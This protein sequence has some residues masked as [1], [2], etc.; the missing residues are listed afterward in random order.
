MPVAV[1][2]F[3]ATTNGAAAMLF[4]VGLRD[5]DNIPW[6]AVIILSA[7]GVLGANLRDELANSVEVSFTL[8]VLAAAMALAGPGGAVLVGFFSYLLDFRKSTMVSRL[9]N[10]AMSACVSGVGANVYALAEGLDPYDLGVVSSPANLLAYLALPMFAG[11]L[12]GLLTNVALIGLMAHF[13]AGVNPFTA[14]LQ[15]VHGLGPTYPVHVLLGILLVVLWAPVGIGPFSSVLIVGPLWLTQWALSRDADERRSHTRTV[16]TLMGAL[17]VATPYS[18][19]HSSRVADLTDRMAPRLGIVGE[20][21]EALHSAALL[22]DLGLV[23]TTPRVPRGTMPNDVSYLA[24][25]QEHPEAGVRMLSD[26]EFLAPAIPGI[27]HHHERYDGLGYPAGL[28]GKHIPLFARVIAVADAFDS[29][30]TNRSYRDEMSATEAV[31]SLRARAGTHLD[32]DVVAAMAEVLE[33]HPWETT[34]ISERVLL[35]GVDAN[36]HDDPIVSDE[37]AAW[38]PESDGLR[39]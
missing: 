26:I 20:S 21:A 6:Q 14:A 22:H 28:V 34:R 37:Y 15:L 4:W 18:I 8:V 7:L 31:K 33:V 19:G 11:F 38:Q 16:S 30:T 9:L 25:I 23:S 27:L 32:P 29:L 12:V 24:A 2:A 36:D 13:S 1:Y 39:A 17:E 35:T 5:Q 10:P 3:V